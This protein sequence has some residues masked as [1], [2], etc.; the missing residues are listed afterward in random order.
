MARGGERARAPPRRRLA[1]GPATPF[2]RP[3]SPSARP[4]LPAAI[5]ASAP[6]LK[7][8]FYEMPPRGERAAPCARFGLVVPEHPVHAPPPPHSSLGELLPCRKGPRRRRRMK[9]KAATARVVGPR[10]GAGR[11]SPRARSTP[12][13]R[14]RLRAR[15]TSPSPRAKGG[16]IPLSRDALW[17]KRR[18]RGSA[19]QFQLAICRLNGARNAFDAPGPQQRRAHTSAR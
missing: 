12:V 10:A 5:P 9:R 1:P 16:K 8:R 6:I 14:G 19:N 3:R 17:Q 7:A 15:A 13:P 2:P 18:R 11:R 4:E